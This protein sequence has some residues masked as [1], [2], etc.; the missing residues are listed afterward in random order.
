MSN[1]KIAESLE[2]KA[3]V[4]EDGKAK[5]CGTSVKV[6]KSRLGLPATRFRKGENSLWTDPEIRQQIA[7]EYW[8]GGVPKHVLASK[9]SVSNSV[10]Q[11][12]CAK[13]KL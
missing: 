2:K 11:R 5:W 12:A 8:T 6:A 4:N 9:Y 1:F 3:I 7:I 13:F 10:V